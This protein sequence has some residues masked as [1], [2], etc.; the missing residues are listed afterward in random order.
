MTYILDALFVALGLIIDSKI[1]YAHFLILL[2]QV[3]LREKKMNLEFF[4]NAAIYSVILPDNYLPILFFCLYFIFN[5]FVTK[6]YVIKLTSYMMSFL[7]LVTVSFV[8]TFLNQVP[9]INIG[10][11]VISFFPFF[12][13]MWMSNS[14][15]K[16]MKAINIKNVEFAVDEILYIQVFA[17]IINLFTRYGRVVE[18]WSYG[19]FCDVGEQAQ[20]FVVI[21]LLSLFYLY[22]FLK[23]KKNRSA[24]YKIIMCGVVMLTTNSWML[25]GMFA[26][27]MGLA[28][29]FSLNP[30]RFIIASICIILLPSILRVG[31]TFL[32]E[33]V[34]SS[35]SMMLADTTYLEYRFHKLIVYGETYFEIPSKDALFAVLGN[36]LGN[37]NSRGALICTGAYTE[38]YRDLFEPSISEYTGE[39][40]VDY[41]QQTRGDYGSVLARPYASLMALMGEVGYLGVFFFMVA[42]VCLFKR[43]RMEIKMLIMVWLSFCFAES[44]FEYPKVIIVLYASI[45]LISAFEAENK[46][47]DNKRQ[48]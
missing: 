24:L 44:Y 37:Y 40:I 10:F 6:G 5:F 13:F 4:L 2:A 11:A 41:L 21:S 12:A 15:D 31:F 32:P 45:F 18:D 14:Y 23:D 1:F 19:T 20:L 46:L 39:Y 9:M 48:Q 22:R 42:M 33:N 16:A 36:G 25:L 38:F 47:S 26:V 34:Q 17:T 28:Y 35:V 29:F 7:L 8:S 27:G 3:L 30:K 43:K